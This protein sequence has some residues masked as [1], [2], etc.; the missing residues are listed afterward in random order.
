MRQ[1]IE[2][3]PRDGNR[4][5]LLDVASGTYDVARWSPEAGQWIGKNGEPSKITPSHWYPMSAEHFL[6]QRDG[7]LSGLRDASTAARRHRFVPLFSIAATLAAA[8]LIGLLFHSDV[9]DYVTRYA[10]QKMMGPPVM[11]QQIPLP[12]DGEAAQFKRA[13]DSATADLQQSLQQER[14]WSKVLE[15]EL[16]NRRRDVDMLLGN[17]ETLLSEHKINEAERLKQAVDS[18]T[19]DLRLTL[20]Q[21][22]DRAEALE[23]EMANARGAMEQKTASVE[24]KPL[25]AW[26]NSNALVNPAQTAVQ[27]E[28]ATGTSK[29]AIR[30]FK[31]GRVKHGARGRYGCQHFQTSPLSRLGPN[32]WLTCWLFGPTIAM[33]SRRPQHTR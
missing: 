30:P 28:V 27:P 18:A 23:I 24:E 32:D 13:V 14:D 26:V 25:A 4:V 10:S 2:T 5:V 21:E 22:R 15:T 12:R 16:V 9:G 7:L 17:V 31:P 20:Q 1:T 6:Q 29:S 19:A 8:A 11:A 3:A 33:P